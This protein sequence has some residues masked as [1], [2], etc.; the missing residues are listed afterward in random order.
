MPNIGKLSTTI[1]SEAEP[2]LRDLKRTESEASGWAARVGSKLSSAGSFA[3]KGAGAALGAAGLGGL[4]SFGGALALAKS[5]A[6]DLVKA[7]HAARMAGVSVLEF[8][9]AMLAA[10]AQSGEMA[11]AITSLSANLGQMQAG[12]ES[13]PT[14]ALREL[15]L[16]GTANV[17]TVAQALSKLDSPAQQAAKAYE[18]LGDSAK[19]V[20]HLLTDGGAQLGKG[21]DLAERFGLGGDGKAVQAF[22]DARMQVEAFGQ[23]VT[24]QLAL[25]AAPIVAELSGSFDGLAGMVR[26][27]AKAIAYG[28]AVAIEAW[29]EV[30]M[31]WD[32]LKIGFKGLMGFMLQGIAWV[33]EKINWLTEKLNTL[34]GSTVGAIDTSGLRE[35]GK[36]WLDAGKKDAD[37]FWAKWAA[38]KSAFAKVDEFFAGVEKR[39]KQAIT[40]TLPAIESL[41]KRFLEMKA[42]VVQANPLEA[43]TRSLSEIQAFAAQGLFKGQAGLQ[44]RFLANAFKGLAGSVQLPEARFAGAAEKMSKEAYSAIVQ[45]QRG[46]QRLTVQE[47][48]LAVKREA[49]AVEKAQLEVGR[50]LLE[51]AKG[52]PALKVAG[53]P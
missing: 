30:S 22:K 50:Q 15:G 14:K 20:M 28:G 24:N 2:F 17:Q 46:E 43:W 45:F 9:G 41:A 19:G 21:Q 6:D 37:A 12:I 47:M 25:G 52:A 29:K 31:V 51:A 4:L 5:G 8:R 33:A 18:I 36:G 42:Q 27:G 40:S 32:F 10:G 35:T 34:T 13:G 49:L 23:G 26:S 38:D 3:A 1:T 11:Q 44:E 39:S 48:L 53:G 16:D 7:D